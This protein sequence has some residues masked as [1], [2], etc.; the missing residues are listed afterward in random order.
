LAFFFLAFVRCRTVV[1]L[2]LSCEGVAPPSIFPPTWF[3]FLCLFP[4]TVPIS[5]FF[6]LVALFPGSSYICHGSEGWAFF[7]FPF[8]FCLDPLLLCRLVFPC[9]LLRIYAFVWRRG[10]S[11]PILVISFFS[12]SW[13]RSS[14]CDIIS[15]S[16]LFLWCLFSRRAMVRLPCTL[17]YRTCF[18][19]FSPLPQCVALSNFLFGG[20]AVPPGLPFFSFC[21]SHHRISSFLFPYA[22]PPSLLHRP[23]MQVSSVFFFYGGASLSFFLNFAF[24][25]CRFFSNSMRRALPGGLTLPHL[26]AANLLPPFILAF[27]S[28]PYC[29]LVELTLAS[30]PVPSEGCV[31]PSVL[32]SLFCFV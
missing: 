10:V 5:P 25:A 26:F 27:P 12:D 30:F 8:A 29:G 4:W 24:A 3:E 2:S 21:D 18:F 20:L 11:G 13:R 14:I 19:S 1:L 6:L 15:H 7:F 31:P 16:L 22:V 32:N 28:F 9:A 23:R 17:L